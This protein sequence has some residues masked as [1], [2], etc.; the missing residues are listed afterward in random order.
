MYSDAC[1]W[2]RGFWQSALRLG[3][4]DF[5]RCDH[6]H[7]RRHHS[8]RRCCPLPSVQIKLRLRSA[9]VIRL[10]RKIYSFV[11]TKHCLC[12]SSDEAAGTGRLLHANFPLQRRNA[13]PLWGET[14]NKRRLTRI[15]PGCT[16][17]YLCRWR[18]PSE[19]HSNYK[20]R[21]WRSILPR[22][23]GCHG[24]IPWGIEKITSDHSSTAKGLL[25]LQI[26]WRSVQ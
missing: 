21:E 6:H 22:K 15:S 19:C 18:R 3:R 10:L 9:V 11:A 23:I 1:C 8:H 16:A 7:H 14:P 2:H 5:G 12:I 4:S 25:T 26:S 17:R 13:A 20:V 24:N